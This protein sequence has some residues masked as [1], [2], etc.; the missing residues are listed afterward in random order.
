[1]GISLEQAR[2]AAQTLQDLQSKA[3]LLPQLENEHS[4]QESLS[5]LEAH[6]AQA[7]SE[8]A[9]LHS[10]FTDML[11]AYK[12]DFDVIWIQ[13]QA[14]SQ[15]L[16][17]ILQLKVQIQQISAQYGSSSM[18]HAIE[19]DALERPRYGYYADSQAIELLGNHRLDFPLCPDSSYW[20]SAI[21]KL[22]T[23]FLYRKRE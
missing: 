19:F 6:K 9:K 8:I 4:K 3:A 22:L 11:V 23:E 10:Q 13:L 5:Q 14:L 7:Q 12:K 21:Y 20:G 17:T 16:S 2:I 18:K 1:M 15:K